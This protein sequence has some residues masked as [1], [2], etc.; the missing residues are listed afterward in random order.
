MRTPLIRHVLALVRHGAFAFPMVLTAAVAP[1]PAPW[2]PDQGD[3][4]FKNPV[5]H[6]DYSDPDAIRVGDD[7]WLVS[8]SFNHAP[9]LP[10]LH[11][12]DLVNWTLANHALPAQIPAE[13]FSVPR[14]GQGVW[15][16][17]IRHHAG[18][19][20]IYYPDPDFGLYLTT[21]NDPRGTWSA[22]V[23]VKAGKGLID[24]CPL[25]D[26]DGQL[27]LVHG[28]AKSRA[29][30]SNLLTLHKLSADGTKPVDEGKIIIDANQLTGWRTLEGPKLYKRDGYYYVFAPAGGVAEGY[31]AIFR[32][33]NI[34]GPYENRI[35]LDQGKSPVNGPHQ[36]AWVDTPSGENWFLHFQ[37]KGL[38]GRVVHLQPMAWRSDGWP[39]MGTAVETGAEKGEPVLVHNKP[40]VASASKKG[41][42]GQPATSDEFDAPTPGLQWQWQA[43]PR[44][45]WLSFTAQPGSAR[46]TSVAAP[47]ENTL[48]LAPNLLMQKF[49]APA[50]TATTRL[51]FSP[52]AE[53]ESAGLIV[54]GYDYGWVG[55]RRS[56]AGTHLVAILNKAADKQGVETMVAAI[57]VD[58]DAV[59]LRVTVSADGQCRFYYSK[60]GEAFLPLDATFKASV[61]RWVGA[62]VGI[63]ASSA[64]GAKKTGFADFEWF[65]ITP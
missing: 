32:S 59:F 1:N 29:G 10:I 24:P 35:V 8:S 30:I 37:D 14:H 60:D 44:P 7:F 21:A 65:R 46:L 55:L 36:G 4:T 54:F 56:A 40:A 16:P 42:P 43:N 49:P 11:S 22:P 47:A 64:P 25:W 39:A 27:Y 51:K 41:V 38:Y 50:F 13:H 61:S 19:F 58:T 15:A 62:K 2:T 23:L 28:W 63:F 31:Q 26:D 34:Y 17:A 6:A 9:G 45:D 57:A 18:K 3:G 33:K 52:A 5:L 53:G 12:R 20:W 48:W